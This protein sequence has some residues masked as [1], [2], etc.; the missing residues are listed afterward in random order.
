M[1]L[2]VISSMYPKYCS[3]LGGV[4]VREQV[5]ELKRVFQGDITVISPVPWAPK[6]LWFNGKWKKYGLT[7]T[8]KDDDGIKILHPRYLAV[9]SQRISPFHGLFMY[10]A[11]SP[12]IKKIT[13]ANERAV[14]HTHTALPDGLVG[15]LLKKRH[16]IPHICTVHGSDI[17]INAF[18]NRLNLFMTKYALKGCDH[19]VAV[20]HR[21][22]EKVKSIIDGGV[23]VS[24]INN[25]ANRDK[26]RM[27]PR[28]EARRRLRITT[29]DKLILYIGNLI[30][31]KGVSNL[32]L[33]FSRLIKQGGRKDVSLFL[34]GSGSQERELRGVSKRL[35][36]DE[37]VFFQGKRPHEEIPF[38]MNTA[39][40]FVLPSLSEGFP[41][42]IPEAMMCGVPVVAT[43]VGGVSEA[44]MD[45]VTGL[46]VKPNDI[47]SLY[48]AISAYLTDSQL[49][50][51][52][53]E[54]AMRYA[55][56][57][58][59]QDNARRYLPIYR[60]IIEAAENRAK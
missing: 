48:G 19:V 29:K 34:I 33:A 21:L 1:R 41:L 23:D 45:K 6:V 52:I 54:N 4:F 16:N 35:G 11:V 55:A 20:S 25:G 58:T 10:L 28:E 7:E 18:E 5:K 56:N 14:I 17:N 50:R 32:L 57:F 8:H 43:D 3:P 42:V 49:T 40:V 38:W 53:A 31:V 27:M 44:I 51:H 36:I 26:Y 60:R 22:K 47:N 9:P 13:R 30:P 12:V 46:L 39:D 59:W 37:K 24:V 2:I 15:A